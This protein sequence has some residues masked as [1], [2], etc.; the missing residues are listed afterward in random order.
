MYVQTFLQERCTYICVLF[1]QG[2]PSE[3]LLLV[4]DRRA[5]DLF[6]RRIGS[7]CGERARFTVRRGNNS[8]G[9]SNLAIFLDR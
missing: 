4:V 5:M 1:N 8:T 7:A 3:R 6:P 2:R 9:D